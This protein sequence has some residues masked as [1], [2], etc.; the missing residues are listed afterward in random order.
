MYTLVC[1]SRKKCCK[2]SLFVPM[3]IIAW[4]CRT[5]YDCMVHFCSA[6][7][8]TVLCMTVLYSTAVLKNA[9]IEFAVESRVKSNMMSTVLK[10]FIWI[11]GIGSIW[12]N[13]ILI[14]WVILIESNW[15]KSIF[16]ILL[17]ESNQ[18]WIWYLT[19]LICFKMTI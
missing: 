3:G 1:F 19:W 4:Y 17:I 6:L 10:I 18:I 12:L 5:C 11:N 9:M 2:D 8:L 15:I 14:S 13:L 7:L 16:E